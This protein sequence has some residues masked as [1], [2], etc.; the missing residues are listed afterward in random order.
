MGGRNPGWIE[1]AL[2]IGIEFAVPA[3]T[4]AGDV[5]QIGELTVYVQTSRDS[6]GNAVCYTPFNFCEVVEVYGRTDGANS[7][8]AIGDKLYTD[9]A[10]GQVNKDNTN[11][12]AFGYALGTVTSGGNSDILVGFGL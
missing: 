11:G 6:D 8:V 12:E 10:D 2:P 9:S 1:Q 3:S 5:V 7:A 4:V